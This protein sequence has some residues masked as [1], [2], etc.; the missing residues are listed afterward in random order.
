MLA[1]VFEENSLV[2][3]L[4]PSFG[5]HS[6]TPP[7]PYAGLNA[8]IAQTIV[9][10]WTVVIAIVILKLWLF[11]ESTRCS[12]IIAET[13]IIAICN[14]TQDAA[15][16]LASSSYY[17]TSIANE[18]VYQSID[19]AIHAISA[20]LM[21][22]VTGIEEIVL[23]YVGLLVGTYECLIVSTIH[24]SADAALNATESIVSFANKTVGDL[25]R[26][27]E[28][29]LE[30]ISSILDDVQGVVGLLSDTFTG[31]DSDWQKVNL[32]VASLQN[33]SLP[34][35][36]NAELQYLGNNV[37]TY[38]DV[39]N[40]TDSILQLPFELLKRDINNTF[41]N[42]IHFNKSLLAVPPK[43]TVS[44]FSP[45]AV[46]NVL[47]QL[48]HDLHRLVMVLSFLLVAIAIGCIVWQIRVET[49]RW[50]WMM[51]VIQKKFRS[52]KVGVSLLRSKLYVINC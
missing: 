34:T 44:T 14:A 35:S 23:F 50:D 4:V 20:G 17:A 40:A 10:E 15:V 24:G 32:T 11:M 31:K 6:W 29:G 52:E 46:Q 43:Q 5:D 45:S 47:A 18:L 8:R 13:S 26:E 1:K 2:A 22:I 33:L 49:N 21:A 19:V 42:D 37:P 3:K 28:S 7:R 41:T 27:I 36:I 39:K 12:L 25:G 51:K 30:E 48:A 16:D 38:E 9:N